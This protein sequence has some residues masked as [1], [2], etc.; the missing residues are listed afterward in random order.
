VTSVES[1]LDGLP[2]LIGQA[3]RTMRE[4]LS[5]IV[6]SWCRVAG[7]GDHGHRGY[8]PPVAL[9]RLIHRR[10]TTCVYPTCNRRSIHCDFDHTVPYDKGGRTCKC[11]IAPL[12]RT[13]HRIFKQHP[14]WQLIQPWPGLLIWVAPAGTWHI[15]VPQ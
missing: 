6:D 11:N 5:P 9:Q 14:Q 7:I 10:H 4:A 1:R 2:M 3:T 12:C 13:H 15:V 8:R